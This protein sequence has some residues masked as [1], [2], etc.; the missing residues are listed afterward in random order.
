[1]VRGTTGVSST[2]ILKSSNDI[3]QESYKN[4]N[5][6]PL[7]NCME[8]GIVVYINLAPSYFRGRLPTNYR[9]RIN[10]SQLSSGWGQSGA[11]EP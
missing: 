3:R 10:V 6:T 7:P 5:K 4:K 9:R 8:E 11:T 1:M 2:K